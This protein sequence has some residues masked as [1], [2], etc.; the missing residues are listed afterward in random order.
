MAIVPFPSRYTPPPEA[1]ATF[2]VTVTVL[3]VSTPPEASSAYTPPPVSPT[4]SVTA[5]FVRTSEAT[6]DT[7]RPP[8]VAEAVFDNSTTSTSSSQSPP[9]ANTPPP[10]EARPFVMVKPSIVPP[11]SVTA[12]DPLKSPSTV[13]AVDPAKPTRTR[14][15]EPKSRFST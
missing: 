12:G 9:D 7:D 1:P 4:L 5:T 6:P 15:F 3:P 10:S 8:P 11:A 2:P 14:C 13:V